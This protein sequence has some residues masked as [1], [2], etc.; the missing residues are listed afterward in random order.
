MIEQTTELL[1]PIAAWVFFASLKSIAII[2]LLLLIRRISA[3]WLTPQS[4]YG[5]WLA[6]IACPRNSVRIAGGYAR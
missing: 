5:L 1:M 6:A 2:P 3:G 4:R